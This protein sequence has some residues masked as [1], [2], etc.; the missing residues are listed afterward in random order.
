[1]IVQ[2]SF[3]L[4]GK[5]VVISQECESDTEVFKFLHHMSEMYDNMVCER[6]G[7]T[8][9]KVKFN[10][11][12]DEDDNE[13]FELVCVDPKNPECN[14]ARRKFGA[15]KKGGGLFPKNKDESGKWKPWTKFN[16]ETRKEE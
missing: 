10:V 3:K 1:M 9:T 5:D 13:Y 16:K 7:Q 6:N 12:T 8:S 2:Y 11:R 4:D 14:Y 15:N